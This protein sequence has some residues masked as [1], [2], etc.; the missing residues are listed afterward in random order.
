MQDAGCRPACRSRGRGRGSA[1]STLHIQTYPQ[2]YPHLSAITPRRILLFQSSLRRLPVCA[3]KQGPL[4]LLPLWVSRR[5]TTT[6]TRLPACLALSGGVCA[7]WGHTGA[8]CPGCL[9]CGAG[10]VRSAHAAR[11]AV[12]P[13]RCLGWGGSGEVTACKSF[14]HASCPV[15]WGYDL[16]ITSH[17]NLYNTHSTV[18]VLRIQQYKLK[19]VSGQARWKAT[20]WW[21]YKYSLLR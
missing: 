3:C 11:A 18:N 21:W 15:L 9:C 17:D 5:T 16:S 2:T 7:S 12:V 10:R 20:G 8:G 6:T 13:V 19:R 14:I 4:P 1:T